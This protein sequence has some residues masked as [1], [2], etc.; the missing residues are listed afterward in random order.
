LNSS[1]RSARPSLRKAKR[2]T[3]GI[4]AATTALSTAIVAGGATTAGAS[5][6][7]VSAPK[8]LHIYH[9][10][11]TASQ[12]KSYAKNPNK[13]VIVLMR[14]QVS[15]TLSGGNAGLRSRSAAL[16]TSQESLQHELTSLHAPNLTQFHFLNAVSATVSSLESARL[17]SN[18]AVLAVVPDA[19][20]SLPKSAETATV[21]KARS[22]AEPVNKTAGLC[23]TAAKPLIQPEAL[24]Q[25]AAKTAHHGITGAGVK[26]AVFPDGLDPAIKDYI[27]P[28]GKH[29]IFDYKDFSGDGP[30]GVTGGGEA[31]GD[32]SSLIAQGRQTFDLSEEVNPNLPLPK[33]CNIRIKGAAPG[34]SLAVMKVFGLGGSFD[35]TIL[36]GMDYAVSHD[37]VDVLSQSFGGNPVP[38]D[39]TD[40]ISVFDADA[41][42]HGITVVA[43]SGDAGITNTIGSPA[44][45]SKGI[46]S[47]GA[48]NSFQLHAQLSEHGYQLAHDKGWLSNNIATLSSSGF[49]SYGP[50]GIDV[51]APGDS[52]WADCSK[53]TNRFLECASSFGAPNPPAIESFGGTSQAC[54]LT[55]SV[56]ALVIQAFKQTHKGAK[57]SPAVVKRIITSTATDLG[58]PADEQGSGQVNA[59]RAITLARSYRSTT[60]KRAGATVAVSPNKI[61][62]TGN[63]GS[64]HTAKITVRNEGAK[65]RTVRPVV[66]RFGA[67]KTIVDNA[68]INLDSASSSTPTYAYWLDGSPEPYV[69]QDFSVPS[70]YQR[71]L[72]RFGNPADPNDPAQDVFEVLYDP[73][74][75]LAQDTDPQGA[76][77]GFGQSD[78][79]NPKPGKWRAIFFSRPGSDKYSGPITHTVTVQKLAI[80]HG[81]VSPFSQKIPAGAAKTFTVKYKTPANPGDAAAAVYF[82]SGI[83]AVPIL[84]RSTVQATVAKPG[85]F[86]GEV[87]TGNGRMPFP[88]QELPYQFHVPAGVKDID[89]DVSVADLGYEVLG[90]LIEPNHT[91]VDMQ[92]SAFVDVTKDE[93]TTTSNRT[94]HLSWQSPVAG[95]WE[96]DL[97]TFSGSSSGKTSSKI[98][99]KISFNTVNVTSTNVPNST[100]TALTAG[101]PTFASVTVKNTGNSPEIYYLDPRL[102]GKSTYS[103]GFATDP[104]GPLPIGDADVSQAFVPPATTSLTMVASA[105]EPVNFTMSPSLGSPEIAS[106]SGKTAVASYTGAPVTAGEWGCPPTLIGPFS[107]PAKAGSYSCGALVTTDTID[108]NAV[109]QGGNLWDSATDPFSQNSFDPTDATVVHPGQTTTIQLAFLPTS[110]E[111]GETVH[112]YLAVQNLNVELVPSSDELVH[113]PYSYKVVAP[114]P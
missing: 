108:D 8:P 53:N 7:H 26:V 72:A 55:A 99:G 89:V 43:S 82:G 110:D 100:S 88:S 24:S 104:N 4:V 97:S 65:A 96:L 20:V 60:V 36:Q 22:A 102:A 79:I 45:A 15:S 56:A 30:K 94:L 69:E 101:E 71:L 29:A 85:T 68:T 95:L 73:S 46:I 67:K 23:G 59:S 106:T 49:T 27:R 81:S 54:P 77:L 1:R 74:G 107:G 39:G 47:V 32:A 114:A 6:P 33:H 2:V 62:A 66:K 41:V 21:S 58:A 51:V 61:A 35:S 78:V 70:G 103:A 42:A 38:S 19:K 28:N 16:A 105:T 76:P 93:P 91:V 84:T 17:K 40:P 31:F 13:R 86:T 52:G 48:T 14:D 18:P 64:S 50:N 98:S 92:P 80:V 34:V 63:P 109:A 37:H 3:A 111:V 83:G 57:P 113:I 12:L 5:S 87:T 25:I 90:T 9:S 10:K 112:G 11:L 75:K 44:S